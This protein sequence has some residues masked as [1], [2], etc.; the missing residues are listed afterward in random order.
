MSPLPRC[1]PLTWPDTAAL[2]VSVFCET[3]I[4]FVLHYI[5]PWPDIM[6]GKWDKVNWLAAQPYQ[7]LFAFSWI[8]KF[9]IPALI[10]LTLIGHFLKPRNSLCLQITLRW[11]LLCITSRCAFTLTNTTSG[12]SGLLPILSHYSFAFNFS[13][14]S[15]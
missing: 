15:I 3:V 1:G 4:L 10:T 12:R 9:W 11:Q 2:A 13:K 5:T 8:L 7:L 14:Y 6:R